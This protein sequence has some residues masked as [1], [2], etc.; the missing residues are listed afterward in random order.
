MRRVARLLQPD[1]AEATKRCARVRRYE[2][3]TAFTT[4]WRAAPKRANHHPCR[5]LLHG[6]HRFARPRFPEQK[7]ERSS[8]GE[9]L[10]TSSGTASS[11]FASDGLASHQVAQRLVGLR[12]LFWTAWLT[13]GSEGPIEDEG[14]PEPRWLLVPTSAGS[15]SQAPTSGD[16]A[17]FRNVARRATVA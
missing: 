15:D 1:R 16:S 14:E 13:R 17:S 9:S 12:G 5:S 2:P 8:S 6:Q 4:F 3:S 11:G 10:R 7:R